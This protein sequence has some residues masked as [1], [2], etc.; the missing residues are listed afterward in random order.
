MQFPDEIL[1]KFFVPQNDPLLADI[2]PQ[3]M[4]TFAGDS[5]QQIAHLTNADASALVSDL[6]EMGYGMPEAWWKEQNTRSGKTGC[7]VTCIFRKGTQNAHH[8]II[9]ALKFRPYYHVYVWDNGANMTINFVAPASRITTVPV[10]ADLE[11]G[12]HQ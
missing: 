3:G 4:T 10:R 9:N 7:V 11:A 5:G 8:S 2:M 6:M 1:V 12:I